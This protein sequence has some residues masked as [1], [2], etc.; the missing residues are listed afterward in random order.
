MIK[1]I[2]FDF[3]GLILDTE[4]TEFIA[5]QEI[6]RQYHYEMPLDVWS[7]WTGSADSVQRACRH[8]EQAI[9]APLDHDEIRSRHGEVFRGMI[10]T[11]DL[12]PGV[13]E[14]LEEGK[15]RGLRIGLATSA[16]YDWAVG[17]VKKY[18]LLDYFDCI[19]TKE[20]VIRSKPDPQIYRE[21]L[22]GLSIGPQEAIAFEDSLFGLQAAKAGGVY[23]VVVPNALTQGFAFEQADLRLQ[24]LLEMDLEQII[25][26]VT[27]Q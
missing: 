6:C 10:A 20:D 25:A 27:R 7:Q 3:D 9:G 14:K 13:I 15:R 21:A 17:Y 18:G 2:L 26:R 23:C 12:L 24:S 5:F 11:A 8:L 4:T 1:A 22:A 16:H 19:R